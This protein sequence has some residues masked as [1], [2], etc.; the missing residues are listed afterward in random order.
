MARRLMDRIAG[1]AGS[2][3]RR[4]LLALPGLAGV[5]LLAYGAWLAWPPLG[6]MVAGV[7]LLVDRA[8]TQALDRGAQ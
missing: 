1:P 3:L 7:A 6:F 4:V 5:A 2:A 8:W